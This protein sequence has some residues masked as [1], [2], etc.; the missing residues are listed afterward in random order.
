MRRT[1]TLASLVAAALMLSV[2]CAH[3][4]VP[5]DA[6]LQ[7]VQSKGIAQ[8]FPSQADQ[9]GEAHQVCQGLTNGGNAD[10]TA[11][12]IARDRHLNKAQVTDFVNTSIDFYC[13]GVPHPQI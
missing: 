6:F 1:A 13:P 11:F 8:N 5:D 2:G 10:S 12:L 4:D 7:A 9:I 3:A